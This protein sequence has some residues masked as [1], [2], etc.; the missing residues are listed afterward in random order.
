M[1]LLHRFYIALFSALLLL[2][3]SNAQTVSVA[4]AGIRPDT[5]ENVTARIQKVIDE[6][7]RSGKTTMTFPKG[8]YDFWPDGAIREQYF[9]S[10]TNNNKIRSRILDFA[11]IACHMTEIIYQA[12]CFEV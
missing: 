8:R 12:W 9:I 4:E 1:S 10:N 6:A 3:T 11:S 7:I 5:Y 2:N